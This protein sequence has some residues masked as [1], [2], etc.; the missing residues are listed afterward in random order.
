MSGAEKTSQKG[1]VK[2]FAAV[3]GS[4]LLGFVYA[5]L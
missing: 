4:A 5:L 2:A 3:A 1:G